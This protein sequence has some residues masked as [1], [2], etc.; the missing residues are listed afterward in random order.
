MPFGVPLSR[1]AVLRPAEAGEACTARALWVR[2]PSPGST[3]A[4]GALWGIA[5]AQT[6]APHAALI[7]SPLSLCSF[8]GMVGRA[9]Y[10]SAWRDD[11]LSSLVLRLDH[12]PSDDPTL[13]RWFVAEQVLLALQTDVIRAGLRREP[14][15]DAVLGRAVSEAGE[16]TARPPFFSDLNAPCDEIED[17]DPL[18]D[19]SICLVHRD[20]WRDPLHLITVNV[21]LSY[22]NIPARYIHSLGP[23]RAYTPLRDRDGAGATAED[24]AGPVFI[25]RPLRALRFMF[26]YQQVPEPEW[27]GR[28]RSFRNRL[29]DEVVAAAWRYIAISQLKD[30]HGCNEQIMTAMRAYLREQGLTQAAGLSDKLLGVL[31]GKIVRQW[32]AG[33]PNSLVLLNSTPEALK[34]VQ[35]K[36]F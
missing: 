5:L 22:C 9:A 2:W 20:Y 10:G 27:F 3:Q 7:E 17:L 24:Y 29:V 34:P 31:T 13:R 36:K 6:H 33:D 28:Y 35:P 21:H 25:V 12:R 23:D 30:R 1:S 15:G 4:A 19:P 18:D 16:R 32:R 14:T 26:S 11:D 8:C